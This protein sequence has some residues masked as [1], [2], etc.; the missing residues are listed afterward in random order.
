MPAR[1]VLMFIAAAA[2]A[3]AETQTYPLDGR[4]PHG[5]RLVHVKAEA[6]TYKGRRAVRL[7]EDG[8]VSGEPLALLPATDFRD[9]TM[10]VDVAGEPGPGAAA[11]ARGFVGIGFHSDPDASHFECFYLR[12]TNGRADDQLRRNH[13]VQYISFPD[14]PWEKLRKEMPGVYES[15]TDLMPGEWTK[16]KIEVRGTKAKLYVNDALQPVLLVNDLK[17]GSRSGAIG[18]WIGSGTVGHFANLRVTPQ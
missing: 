5:L 1:H 13:S 16:V 11:G 14:F 9:G 15:Y 12:P 8:G 2:L 7:T 4:Q 10:Q 18:L 6:V 3:A 17:L